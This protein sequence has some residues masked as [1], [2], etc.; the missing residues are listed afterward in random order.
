[1]LLRYKRDKAVKYYQQIHRRRMR[2]QTAGKGDYSQWNIIYKMLA[3]RGLFES[4]SISGSDPLKQRPI[5]NVHGPQAPGT[6]PAE[7]ERA[8]PGWGHHRTALEIGG[9]LE[10]P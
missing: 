9:I 1:M 8:L 10:A 3:N 7:P 5:A 4:S 2:D 6:V